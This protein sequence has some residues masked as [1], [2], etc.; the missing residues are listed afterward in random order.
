MPRDH[1]PATMTP[2]EK[3]DLNLSRQPKQLIHIPSHAYYGNR[4]HL[5]SRAQIYWL[6]RATIFGYGLFR[7]KHNHS[8]QIL[9]I[10]PPFPKNSQSKSCPR[11]RCCPIRNLPNIPPRSPPSTGTSYHRVSSSLRV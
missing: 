5:L 8:S 7:M 1:K 4:L 9:S 3:P 2:M 10:D 11:S 6:L